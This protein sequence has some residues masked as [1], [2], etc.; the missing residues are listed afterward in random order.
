MV[1][2]S[3]TPTQVLSCILVYKRESVCVYTL[4]FICIFLTL[5][6]D[7]YKTSWPFKEVQ[8]RWPQCNFSPS[9]G[10]IGQ[11]ER[12]PHT[13]VGVRSLDA[14][15]EHSA[16]TNFNPQLRTQINMS[17][18][19]YP[20]HYVGLPHTEQRV[21]FGLCSETVLRIQT[22]WTPEQPACPHSARRQTEHAQYLNQYCNVQRSNSSSTTNN[23][24]NKALIDN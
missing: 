9:G 17:A 24:A 22:C 8:D 16:I 18:F 7:C 20:W 10:L 6:I 3:G 5:Q 14:L 19:T 12:V 13:C 11:K 21:S 2:W 1:Q 23:N 15:Q 4:C